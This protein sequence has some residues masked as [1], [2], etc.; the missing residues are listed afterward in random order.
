MRHIGPIWIGKTNLLL[1]KGRL[2]GP[3]EKKLACWSRKWFS[4]TGGIRSQIH[5]SINLVDPWSS[6]APSKTCWWSISSIGNL[7][8]FQKRRAPPVDLEHWSR[9][10][11]AQNWSG[12]WVCPCCLLSFGELSN[13]MGTDYLS[14]GLIFV[15]WIPQQQFGGK[16]YAKKKLNL[17]HLLICKKSAYT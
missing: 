13:S 6:A 9:K 17:R 2:W 14:A 15:K 1:V 4:D 12:K 5:K 7:S 10:T 11:T 8:T 3:H 16:Y